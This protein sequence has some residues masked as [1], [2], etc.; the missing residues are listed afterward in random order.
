M[1]GQALN[2]II[3]SDGSPRFAMMTLLIGA[4]LNII[5]DPICI[6][7]L[8][9]G[10]AGAAIATIIGQIVSAIMA[11]AYLFRMKA[12]HLDKDCF[13]FRP[14]LMQNILSLGSASFLSQISFVLSMA[15]TLNM[16]VKY[17]ALDVI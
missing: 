13:I 7:I 17:G 1:F 16:A 10:M 9:W 12:V 3:R 4:V 2:P 11:A 8:H 6:Y 15:S 5:L 14:A